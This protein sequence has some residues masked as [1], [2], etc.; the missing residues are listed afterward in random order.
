MYEKIE[1]EVPCTS[2]SNQEDKRTSRRRKE[3]R[4]TKLFPKSMQSIHEDPKQAR[5]EMFEKS[6]KGFDFQSNSRYSHS[7]CKHANTNCDI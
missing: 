6:P 4:L 1:E 3:Y 2:Y 7:V 5:R